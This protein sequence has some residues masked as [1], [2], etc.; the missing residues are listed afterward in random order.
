MGGVGPP[1]FSLSLS[2][3]DMTI[4]STF[5]F[6]TPLGLLRDSERT[7]NPFNELVRERAR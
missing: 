5:L 3:I 7:E 1:I 6:P 2:Q 4:D